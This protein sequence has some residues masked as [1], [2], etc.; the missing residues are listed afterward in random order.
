MGGLR[1]QLVPPSTPTKSLHMES[2]L[3]PVLLQPALPALP[4]IWDAQD[5]DRPSS[6]SLAQPKSLKNKS[7]ERGSKPQPISIPVPA[8]TR[9]V[10]ITG[11]NTG[12]KTASLKTVGASTKL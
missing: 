8:A 1:P 11:P 3:N 12:G 5:S 6:N 4:S 2:V 9:V 7:D 10:A